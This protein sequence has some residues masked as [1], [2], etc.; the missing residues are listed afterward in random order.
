MAEVTETALKPPKKSL[1]V[2]GLKEEKPG[3]GIKVSYGGREYDLT[4]LSDEDAAYLL[5]VG[6]A[7]PYL[8]KA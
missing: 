8:V 5:S 2:V 4:R 7:F 3:A 6:D 1:K